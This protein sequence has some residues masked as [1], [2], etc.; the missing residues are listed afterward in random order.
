MPS[1]NTIYR[2]FDI[3]RTDAG[4]YEWT[5]DRGFKHDGKPGNLFTTDEQAMND[6]DAYK[7]NLAKGG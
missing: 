1:T 2:G 7:R 3:I 5:D 6:I 4:H